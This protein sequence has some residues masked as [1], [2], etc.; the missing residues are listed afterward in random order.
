MDKTN[1][2]GGV[3]E[4]PSFA[5]LPSTQALIAVVVDAIAMWLNQPRFIVIDE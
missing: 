3:K 4:A 2:L 1:H 5:A